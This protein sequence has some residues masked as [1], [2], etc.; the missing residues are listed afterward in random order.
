MLFYENQLIFML[1]SY[2]LLDLVNSM[3][4]LSA[5][6]CMTDGGEFFGMN[7]RNNKISL[8]VIRCGRNGWK[9]SAFV[10]YFL[11]FKMSFHEFFSIFLFC[12]YQYL[13]ILF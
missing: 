6:V 12:V 1:S 7:F 9:V 11:L 3:Q 5:C 4:K 2:I 13:Q 10:V 8:L